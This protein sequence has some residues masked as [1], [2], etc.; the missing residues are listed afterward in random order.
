MI[1]VMF[2]KRFFPDAYIII[3]EMTYPMPCGKNSGFPNFP[4]H[5][6]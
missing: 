2:L 3:I 6:V 4:Q 1:T 5:T